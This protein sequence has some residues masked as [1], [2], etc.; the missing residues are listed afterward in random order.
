MIGRMGRM[1]F[2]VSALLA[3][4]LA[5][6]VL[7]AALLVGLFPSGSGGVAATTR[8]STTG[9]PQQSAAPTI[10]PTP[11]PTASPTPAPTFDPATGGTYTVQPGEFLSLIGE[12]LGVPWQLIAQANDIQPPD[13]VIVPG[14][15]LTIPAVGAQPTGGTGAEFHIVQPGDTITA[16]A[17]QYGV[18]PTDL[19][20][21]NNIA[22]WNSIR[23][24]D[25]LFIPG[26]GWT[27]LPEP[28][29]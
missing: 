25:Q 22:D 1:S 17:Q 28:T 21:F 19:A 12:K 7:A 9:L 11:T 13:Y 20:D 23:V 29:F 18:D 2:L 14:Q 15:V 24:G 5:A 3:C 6:V 27:P 26:P 8:P 16:I 10:P 4:S